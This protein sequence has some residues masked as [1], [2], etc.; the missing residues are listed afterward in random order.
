MFAHTLPKFLKSK[1]TTESI[2]TN[3]KGAAI[4]PPTDG[5]IAVI[6][7]FGK[8]LHP[9]AIAPLVELG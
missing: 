8:I 3:V 1:G 5:E 6:E 7:T 4:L 2:T 9:E